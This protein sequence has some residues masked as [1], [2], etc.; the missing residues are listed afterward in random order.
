MTS[1]S[2][3]P[4]PSPALPDDVAAL[5]GV[6]QYEK[7]ADF[8]VEQG[9]VWTSCAS[10]SNGNPLYWDPDVAAA[11]TGGPISPP[12]LLSAYAR[13]HYWAPGAEG[14]QLSLQVHFDLKARFGLPEAIM[15]D[16]TNVFHEPVR[17]GDFITSRQILR[18]VGPEKRTKLG[19]GRFWV[20]DVEYHN[21]RGALVGTES[22][23]GYGYRREANS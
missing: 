4:S 17:V 21:Q 18:S 11:V 6:T 19:V 3:S 20:I 14:E 13:P 5:I 8:P 22:Y 10:V 1:P 16:N 9:Y 12:S 2:P 15:T 7:T 23:T